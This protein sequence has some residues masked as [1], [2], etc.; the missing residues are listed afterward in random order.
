M[1]GEFS[2]IFESGVIKSR[3]VR[4]A[5][6]ASISDYILP[7]P[8]PPHSSFLSLSRIWFTGFL[9]DADTPRR[10]VSCFPKGSTKNNKNSKKK[11]NDASNRPLSSGNEARFSKW[12]RIGPSVQFLLRQLANSKR[13]SNIFNLGSILIALKFRRAVEKGE[14]SLLVLLFIECCQTVFN[15]YL[16]IKYPSINQSVRE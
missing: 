13:N 6:A 14:A 10:S 1:A 3:L 12:T 15:K 5:N 7:S 2:L 4:D 9:S 11:K 16:R 8:P